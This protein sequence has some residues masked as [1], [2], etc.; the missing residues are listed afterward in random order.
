MRGSDGRTVGQDVGSGAVF[1]SVS[2]PGRVW[3]LVRLSHPSYGSGSRHVMTVSMVQPLQKPMGSGWWHCTE[4]REG[5]QSRL[6]CSYHRWRC[7]CKREWRLRMRSG[8]VCASVMVSHS[9]SRYTVADDRAE[10]VA[11]GCSCPAALIRCRDGRCQWLGT[12]PAD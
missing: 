1:L 9:H 2:I 10:V 12:T 8:I 5:A 6:T 4:H 7:C 3:C 11:E